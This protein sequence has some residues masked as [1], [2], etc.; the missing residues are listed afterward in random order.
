MTV[1]D[2]IRLGNLQLP[3]ISR[4]VLAAMN[5]FVMMKVIAVDMLLTC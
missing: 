2:N 1:I 5:I 4:V 3:T